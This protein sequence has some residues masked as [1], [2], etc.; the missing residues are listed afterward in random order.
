[1]QSIENIA[2]EILNGVK[3]GKNYSDYAILVRNS[4]KMT[5]YKQIFSKYNISL[6]FKEK[7][8][9]TTSNCFNILYNLFRFLDNTTRDASLIALLHSEIFDYSNDE[10]LNLSLNNGKTLFEKLALSNSV[11]SKNTVN[12]LNK[13]LDFSLNNSLSDILEKIVSDIDFVNYLVTID[14][15]DDEVDYYENFI[16]LV[17]E[18]ENTDNKLSGFV[19]YLKNIKDDDNSHKYKK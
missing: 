13:W 10:L 5:T 15:N 1:M 18:S 8:G 2:Y 3:N 7:V 14:I 17:Q 16:D 6:F 4:T 12:L 19:Q 9:F 11:K